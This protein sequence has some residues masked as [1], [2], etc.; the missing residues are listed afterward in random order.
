[1]YKVKMKQEILKVIQELAN[2]I[3]KE[4]IDIYNEASIQYELAILLRNYI[5]GN[6]K[7][8]LERNI[9][10]FQLPK[11]DYLKKEMDIVIFSPDKLMKYCIELK[12]PTNGQYPE[13]MFSACK[14]I[15]FL[16]E[17]KKAGFEGGLFIMFANDPL[18]YGDFNRT[19]EDSIYKK[20]R[21]EKLLEGEIKKPT[22]KKDE[23]IKLRGKYFIQWQ[24]VREN[25][26]YFIIET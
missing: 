6:Y 26:K 23:I 7:V 12:F 3:S 8:Q 18:F 17:L 14:D 11:S 20:F 2:G 15:G 10:Y 21:S 25:F 16:E 13:Q 24:T 19:G 5:G 9:N 22:G 4:T 1:M